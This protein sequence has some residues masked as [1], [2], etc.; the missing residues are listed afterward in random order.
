MIRKLL[1]VVG[2]TCLV[3]ANTAADAKDGK[4]HVRAA[5]AAHAEPVKFGAPGFQQG[6]ARMIEVAPG[7]FVSSYGC[8]SDEGYGRRSPCDLTDGR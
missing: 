2:A 8:I 1:L 5:K 7:R 3:A 6:P 4:R